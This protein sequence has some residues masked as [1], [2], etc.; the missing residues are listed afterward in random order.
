MT[1]RTRAFLV[2]A[3]AVLAV[4][5]GSHVNCAR[6]DG[7][8]GSDVL[9][10]QSYFV[11]GDAGVSL[12][13][14]S[15]LGN[16]LQ[17]AVHAHFPVRVAII[18]TPQ[19]LGAIT[20]LWRKPGPYAAF[21]GTELSLSYSG[22]LLIVMPDG[23]GLEWQGHSTTSGYRTLSHIAIG[24]GGSGLA[25]AAI[26]AVRSLAAADG[27]KLGSGSSAQPTA[28]PTQS[29][30]AV[31]AQSVA[32]STSQ[33][34]PGSGTDTT[35]AII[36]VALLAAGGLAFLARR[37]LV[38]WTRASMRLARPASAATVAIGVTVLAGGAA[39]A[40]IAL[41][42][43]SPAQNDALATNPY[44]DPGTPLSR[45]APTFTLTDQF[46]RSIS[47]SSFRGKVV[48][49]A[50]N[51]SEC[52]TICPLTTTAMLDAKAML[53]RAGRDVQ[54]LGV[55][56]NPKATS[57]EDVYTYS[58]LHGMLGAWHFLTG[59]LPALQ[60]IWGA[61]RVQAAIEAGEIAHTPALFVIDPRGAERELYI[62]QQ[63]YASIGQLGQL[64]AQEASRLLPGHP[65][66]S[67]HLSY[68]PVD[69][70]SP[71]TTV[72]RARAGGGT[73]RLGPGR[74]HLYV[75]FATWDREVTGLAAGLEGLGR[76][77]TLAGHLGLP[78]VEAVDEASVEP[79][80]ALKQFLAGLGAPLPYPIALDGD[81]RLADGYEVQG[82]PWLMV[83][84][85]KGKIAW[86]Y[87]V[88]ALGWPS[89]SELITK[90]REA[91]TYAA[92][93][94]TTL[95]AALAKLAGSPPELA[96]V[97]RQANQLLAGEPALAARIR[98]LRGYPI[99]INAWASWC[100]PCQSEFGLFQ[101]ASSRYG[102]QVAFLGAD[103]GDSTVNAR[104]FLG[105]HP[106]SY[107][108]YQMSI[109]SLTGIIP[110]GVAGLPTTIFISRAGKLAYVHSGQYDSQG[111]LD[112]DIL[113]YALGG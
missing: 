21:L 78:S 6:A 2:A 1:A 49:L 13:E 80:G 100:V 101:S 109:P 83:V 90:V 10:N 92:G 110:Q 65:A 87:S 93:G 70:I 98:A 14:E 58:Q 85:A 12:S 106:V 32:P 72:T 34:S 26:T 102:R 86:Y 71:A 45:P 103:S 4:G 77:G 66:V 30:Q 24:P 42:P 29:V 37:R 23:F 38:S 7:D 17:A 67:S 94:P 104:G 59:T 89:T 28:E 55:D 47:L 15:R 54:L 69:G 112:G 97:H 111:S 27:V 43:Q 64:L 25:V 76:Y 73:V 107:P 18:A 99:V 75:F 81:G 82:L 44:L 50:F 8:P 91:L 57:L 9:V 35:V 51:D 41:R 5:F 16:L 36:A 33:S 95:A 56:A 40:V 105:Q 62:T 3:A 52:T 48:L 79:P 22:R 60:R 88:S 19:D 11:A 96:A 84:S 31:P 113:S 20:A 39:A 53:G 74:A 61:Y 63:S 68:V 108:S 46:G